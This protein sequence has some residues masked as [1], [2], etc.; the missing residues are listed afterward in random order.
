MGEGDV[1]CDRGTAGG[2]VVAESV[3]CSSPVGGC[4]VVQRECLTRFR[5]AE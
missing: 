2:K 3:W 1:S 5:A 4:E